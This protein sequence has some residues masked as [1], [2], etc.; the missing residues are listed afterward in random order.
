MGQGPGG[1]DGFGKPR[2]AAETIGHELVLNVF[3]HGGFTPKEMRNTRHI[4]QD[5]IPAIG[6]DPG[7]VT[8][9]PAAK[10][11]ETGDI[12][13][14]FMLFRQE[15]GHGG[16]GIGQP[17]AAH[18]AKVPGGL[19]EGRQPQAFGTAFNQREGQALGWGGGPQFP[20][21]PDKA[22]HRKGREPK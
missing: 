7:A 8:L 9:H 20:A 13:F 14:R 5:A 18:Q 1:T 16:A 3:L 4:E 11:Q 15:I 21:F 22:L 17:L 19:I 6:R 10:T 12:F 2:T